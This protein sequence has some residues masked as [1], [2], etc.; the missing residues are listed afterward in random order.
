MRDGKTAE[1]LALQMQ[2][3][4]PGGLLEQASQAATEARQQLPAS[5]AESA[6]HAERSDGLRLMRESAASSL[7]VVQ[8]ETQ[9]GGLQLN[10]GGAE[11]EGAAADDGERAARDAPPP[12]GRARGARPGFASVQ[13]AEGSDK[14]SDSDEGE[15]E[16]SDQGGQGLKRQRVQPARAARSR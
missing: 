6:A 14:D 16:D 8:A 13:I 2:V 7:H 1:G 11:G 5:A 9:L 10:E 12:A 4:G 15:G 3:V